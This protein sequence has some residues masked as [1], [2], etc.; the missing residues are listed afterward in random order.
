MIKK[1]K[2]SKEEDDLIINYIQRHGSIGRSWQALSDSLGL[3]TARHSSLF[4]HCHLCL[5]A[6]SLLDQAA[7]RRQIALLNGF[8]SYISDMIVVMHA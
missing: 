6:L 5:L 8:Y 3:Y 2:W 1:G 7:T 4:A